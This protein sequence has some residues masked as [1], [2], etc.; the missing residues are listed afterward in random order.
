[1]HLVCLKVPRTVSP[2]R[3]HGFRFRLGHVSLSPSYSAASK[4]MR[5]EDRSGLIRGPVMSTLVNEASRYA[6]SVP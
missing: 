6:H 4:L 1:V 2:V 3:S 5:P